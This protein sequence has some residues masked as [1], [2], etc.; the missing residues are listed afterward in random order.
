MLLMRRSGTE[1]NLLIEKTCLQLA[2]KWPPTAYRIGY[3]GRGIGKMMYGPFGILRHLRIR[4]RAFVVMLLIP[5]NNAHMLL[6][7]GI[8]P[9]RG[10]GEIINS[11]I[12]TPALCLVG[13]IGS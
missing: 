3:N 11:L 10:V 5:F 7:F 4:F 2:L 13:A 6:G 1:R 8:E 9:C 12:P